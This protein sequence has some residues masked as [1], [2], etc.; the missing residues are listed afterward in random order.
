[1]IASCR[2][3]RRWRPSCAG[4]ADSSPGT[5]ER[6]ERATGAD[7]EGQRN[8]LRSWCENLDHLV[9]SAGEAAARDAPVRRVTRRQAKA[10]GPRQPQYEACLREGEDACPCCAGEDSHMPGHLVDRQVPGAVDD[11]ES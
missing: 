8:S 11:A 6:V 9:P 7:V 4:R 1:M 3:E 10:A 2:V 5:R